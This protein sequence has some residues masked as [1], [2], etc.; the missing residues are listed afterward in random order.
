MSPLAPADAVPSSS[1]APVKLAT[2][3]SAGAATSSAA[4]PLCRILPSTI[5]P[6]WSASAA[7]SSKSW[8]TRIVGSASSRSSSWSSIRT[9]AFVWASSAEQRLV[10]QQD[11]RL[12]RE[13]PRERDP[14][15]LAARQL[16]D[17]GR[18]QVGD[19]EPLEQLVHG[20]AASGAEADVR[21]HVEVGEQRVLLEQVAHPA[22]LRR[23]V[24]ALAACRARCDRRAPRRRVRGRS[25]PATTR[26]TVVLPAPDGPT[27]AVVAPSGTV[28]WTDASKLRRGWVKWTL[29]AIG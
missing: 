15:A 26:S 28:S 2:N 14:L 29:S 6:T 27:S 3:G 8:V 19:P 16:A 12:E 11:A 10:E 5:T 1:V 18:G 13:R 24:D 21:E 22:T 25:S 20:R 7:A 23:H 17:A 9:A 4:V